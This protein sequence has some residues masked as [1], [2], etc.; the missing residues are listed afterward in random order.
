MKELFALLN[1]IPPEIF[2]NYTDLD[3]FFHKAE[4]GAEEKEEKSKKVFEA[5]HMILRPFL[6]RRAKSDAGKNLL[7]ST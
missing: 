6:L 2:V 4:T 3:S 1:F 7:S 5:L